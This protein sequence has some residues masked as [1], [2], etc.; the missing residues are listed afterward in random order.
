MCRQCLSL[1]KNYTLFVF[2]G[3]ASFVKSFGPFFKHFK[4]KQFDKVECTFVL[5]VLIK[6]EEQL[7]TYFNLFPMTQNFLSI[8]QELLVLRNFKCWNFFLARLTDI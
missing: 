2:C 1:V 7:R 5:E 8:Y 3:R 6:T 4:I